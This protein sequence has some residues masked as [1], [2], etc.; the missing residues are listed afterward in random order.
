M[1]GE[2]QAVL[3]LLEHRVVEARFEGGASIFV[4]HVIVEIPHERFISQGLIRRQKPYQ[5]F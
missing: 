4:C 1:D 2:L 3:I 5:V